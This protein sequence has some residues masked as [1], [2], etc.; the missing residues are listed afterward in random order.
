[1]CTVSR[2]CF[3]SVS[4]F[5]GPALCRPVTPTYERRS[6]ESPSG[7]YPAWRQTRGMNDLLARHRAVIP[8]WVGLY[9]DQPLE[10]TSG[11][12][13]RVTDA[14][15]RSYLDFFAGILTNMLGYDI[16]EG[17]EA[18][19]RQLATGIVHPSTLYLIP[20]QVELAEK[21]APLSGIPDAKVF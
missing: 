8:T 20:Q 4:S 7:K 15:G 6:P 16:P 10:I 5:P 13:C 3:M 11:K 17:R 18:V 19:D 1:M 21:I 14:E 9:Y 12:G 2:Y